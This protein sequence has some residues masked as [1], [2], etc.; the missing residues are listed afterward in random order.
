MRDATLRT[1][2]QS[3]KVY[4]PRISVHLS[5]RKPDGLT[6]APEAV[7][8]VRYGLAELGNGSTLA[9]MAD[10]IV[11]NEGFQHSDGSWG[12]LYVGSALDGSLADAVSQ[13]F[14]GCCVNVEAMLSSEYD[15]EGVSL[16]IGVS[17]DLNLEYRP[18]SKAESTRLRELEEDEDWGAI[19]AMHRSREVIDFQ[20][21]TGLT[22]ESLRVGSIPYSGEPFM[23]QPTSPAVRFDRLHTLQ[24]LQ[25]VDLDWLFEQDVV[26][27]VQQAPL[28]VLVGTDMAWRVHSVSPSGRTVQ[29]LPMQTGV[30]VGRVAT[31]ASGS[32]IADATVRVEPGG[33]ETQTEEDGTFRLEVYEGILW[34]LLVT[35]DGYIPYT[36]RYYPNSRSD[37]DHGEE[38]ILVRPGRE[39]VH[40]VKLFEMPDT[41][42]GTA[43][44]KDFGTFYG[45]LGMSFRDGILGD[46]SFTTWLYETGEGTRLG[47]DVCACKE[48]QRGLVDLGNQGSKP[49]EDIPILPFG[50]TR[51]QIELREG[52]VYMVKASE[53]FEDRYVVFRVLSMTKDGVE[54][55]YLFR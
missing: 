18:W 52:S 26:G 5:E 24:I 21:S 47:G 45:A 28:G 50:Y 29:L 2:E 43:F 38:R 39:T 34:K 48:G 17:A 6:S 7:G 44:L 11:M 12:T 27:E 55:S 13:P 19:D 15:G 51:G 33:F 41:M 1:M 31:F 25:D 37:T 10:V 8:E 35:K 20:L 3:L 53:G 9:I 22:N 46:F 14:N 49:L 42:L 32:P 16:S 40:T 36:A 30:L 54:I 23:L 4:F